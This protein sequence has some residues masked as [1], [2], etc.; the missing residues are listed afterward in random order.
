MYCSSVEGLRVSQHWLCILNVFKHCSMMLPI[1]EGQVSLFCA[2]ICCWNLKSYYEV[3][4]QSF[5]V[6]S[7]EKF[8][9]DM[10]YSETSHLMRLLSTMVPRLFA[11]DCLQAIHY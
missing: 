4:S 11:I 3:I 2:Q 9:I 7:M 1:H 6:I 10:I 5:C 8:S